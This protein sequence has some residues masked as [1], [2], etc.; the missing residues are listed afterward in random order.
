MKDRNLIYYDYCYVIYLI[1][2][3]WYR[4]VGYLCVRCGWVKC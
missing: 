1:L 3:K 2:G 4:Y